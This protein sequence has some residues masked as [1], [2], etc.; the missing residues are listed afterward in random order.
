[1]RAK[2]QKS[3]ARCLALSYPL[4][5]PTGITERPES[6]FAEPKSEIREIPVPLLVPPKNWAASGAPIDDDFES[7]GSVR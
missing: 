2:K 4:V 7:D 3:Q 5:P 1:V 6:G